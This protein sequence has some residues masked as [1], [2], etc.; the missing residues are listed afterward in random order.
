MEGDRVVIDGGLRV[1]YMALI[2]SL[3]KREEAARKKIAAAMG[4]APGMLEL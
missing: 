2:D 1:A 3:A 4:I